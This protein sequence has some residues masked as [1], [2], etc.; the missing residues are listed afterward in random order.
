MVIIVTK[1]NKIHPKANCKNAN[2]IQKRPFMALLVV[3]FLQFF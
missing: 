3:I 1:A 2:I